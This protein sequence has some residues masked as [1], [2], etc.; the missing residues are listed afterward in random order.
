MKISSLVLTLLIFPF[1]W[2]QTESQTPVTIE[3]PA[4]LE[5]AEISKPRSE[6]WMPLT[7]ILWPGLS[8]A[9]DGQYGKSAAYASYA[10][11]GWWLRSEVR[12][13]RS[14]SLE[15]QDALR[16]HHLRDLKNFEDLSYLINY[17]AVF[18]SAYDS[19]RLR[20]GDHQ[21][22][23]KYQ[24]LPKEQSINDILK[25]P[26]SFSYLKRPTTWVPFL[27]A[28]GVGADWLRRTPQPE[29]WKIRAVDV[30]VGSAIS[31][32]AGTGEEAFFRGYMY[33]VLYEKWN[34]SWTANA[35]QSAVFGLGHPSNPF[36]AALAGFYF[37]WLTE[38]NGFDL[39]EA[40]FL[41]AWWDF[42]V[43]NADY[44]RRRSVTEDYYF[45]L[46]PLQMTF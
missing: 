26:F 3:N 46:P 19:F 36:E 15:D 41:H 24:F 42:W 43:I 9:I 18:L 11:A 8:Q 27:V 39:G 21:A 13:R 10:A 1:A 5:P 45:R 35:A 12:Q 4:S 34:G 30:G 16:F 14:E 20:V 31:Y 17:H 23:G 28:I 40:T 2:S 37:G 32:N 22:K 25:A 38:R 33:P 6:I 7:N 44:I 29:Q